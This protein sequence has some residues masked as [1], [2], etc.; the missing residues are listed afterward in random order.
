RRRRIR[1]PPSPRRPSGP[2]AASRTASARGGAA[3]RSRPRPSEATRGTPWEKPASP[4]PAPG[5]ARPGP[6][7]GWPQPPGAPAP[8]GP[9]GGRTLPEGPGYEVLGVRG[10]GGMG[11]VYRARQLK[12]DRVVALKMIRAC[13]HAAEHDRLRFR[14]E[15]EAVARLQHPNIVQLYEA[16]EAGG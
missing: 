8:G 11:V 3:G 7:P 9:G 1:T 12:A 5:R 16:G 4:T 6:R 10:E 14:I 15:T 2:S 13:E